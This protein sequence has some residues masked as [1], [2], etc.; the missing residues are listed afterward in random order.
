MTV[1]E[2][3]EQLEK[4]DDSTEVFIEG[5]F[6]E[7]LESIRRIRVN[8]RES[9]LG[10]DFLF[11]TRSLL[12]LYFQINDSPAGN[13]LSPGQLQIASTIIFE[14]SPRVA[15]LAPTGYGKSEAVALAAAFCCAKYDEGIVIAAQTYKTAGIIMKTVIEHLFDSKLMSQELEIDNKEKLSRLKRERNKSTINFRGGGS[16]T[17]VSLHGKDDDVSKAIGEHKRKVILD[18]SPLL[19]AA[20]YLMVLK[21]MEGTGEYEDT[22][23]FELGNAVN[24]N[25]F[26]FNVKSNP[27]YLRLDIPLDQAI[28]E[29]R[30]SLESVEEKRGLPFF[31]QFYLCQFPAADE[32]DSKGFR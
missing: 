6:M 3:K 1:K 23:L 7:N 29:G 4:Y 22:F 15:C 17:I 14:E 18:E 8:H 20:E 21:I 5:D 2:L 30:L 13:E 31:E 28:A 24:R 12:N 26:M 9:Y 10:S 16:I 32:I 27:K 25:H 11:T 19:T